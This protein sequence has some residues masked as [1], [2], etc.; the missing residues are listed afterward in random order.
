MKYSTRLS[1][2]VH[3]LAYIQINPGKELTSTAIAESI[4]TNSGYVR[5]IMMHLKKA[6]LL[7]NTR[8]HANPKLMREPGRITILDVYHAVEGN[9]PLLHL[10][11]NINPECNVGVNI[12]LTL[13]EHY[14][15]IQRTAEKKMAQ[16]TLEDIIE[17]YEQRLKEYE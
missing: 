15:E 12:Q 11:T 13:Q 8:G 1:D 10:D 16:I 5:Q 9:K 4:H 17:G 3:I 14:N 2:A 6:E 7:S